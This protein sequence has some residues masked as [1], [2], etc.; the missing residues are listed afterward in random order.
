MSRE[1]TKTSNPGKRIKISDEVL[2][3]VK[4]KGEKYSNSINEILRERMMS[5]RKSRRRAS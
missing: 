1:S 3:W 4:S 5:E 2:E